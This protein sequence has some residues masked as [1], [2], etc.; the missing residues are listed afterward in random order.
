MKIYV[1]DEER[2]YLAFR[3]GQRPSD[4]TAQ[5][6]KNEENAFLFDDIKAAIIWIGQYTN[7]EKYRI[8]TISSKTEAEK[9]SRKKVSA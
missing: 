3:K 9:L 8:V 7:P 6:T 2:R 4:L 1:M 5:W